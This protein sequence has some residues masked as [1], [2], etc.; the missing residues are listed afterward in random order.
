MREQAVGLPRGVDIP[1]LDLVER[2]GFAARN[3]HN[4]SIEWKSRLHT[5]S[6]NTS[7]NR[8]H[9]NYIRLPDVALQI[10]HF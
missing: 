2:L 4:F 10:A 8:L 5:P 6:L 9:L 7:D 1:M 3:R